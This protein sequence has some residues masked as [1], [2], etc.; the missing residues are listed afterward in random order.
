[1][2]I[3]CKQVNWRAK[4]VLDAVVTRRLHEFGRHAAPLHSTTRN[5]VIRRNIHGRQ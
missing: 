3:Y 2:L 1:M 5:Q 4:A